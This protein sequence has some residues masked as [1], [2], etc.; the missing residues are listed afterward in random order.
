V[1]DVIFAGTPNVTTPL[2][3]GDICEVDISGI[4]VLRNPVVAEVPVE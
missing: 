3:S 4:G 1:G 2:N